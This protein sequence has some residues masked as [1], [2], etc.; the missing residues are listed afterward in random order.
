MN[1]LRFQGNGNQTLKGMSIDNVQLMKAGSTFNV[2]IN[3]DFE[4]P[5]RMW[6]LQLSQSIP[7]W[8]SDSLIKINHGNAYNNVFRSR[9]CWFGSDRI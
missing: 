8:F 2:L 6:G 1:Y 7:G 5:G 9:V 3:G 4:S